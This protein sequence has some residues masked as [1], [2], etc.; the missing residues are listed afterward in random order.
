[1]LAIIIIRCVVGKLPDLANILYII[2]NNFYISSV[3]LVCEIGMYFATTHCCLRAHITTFGLQHLY[4][5]AGELFPHVAVTM[6]HKKINLA[7]DLLA[8]EHEKFSIRRLP[9]FTLSHLDSHKDLKRNSLIDT[10]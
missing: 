9:A 4:K 7:D 1:M 3:K 10:R 8:W 2:Y 5:V 6:K